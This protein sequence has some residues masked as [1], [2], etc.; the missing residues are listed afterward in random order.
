M[1]A[2]GDQALEKMHRIVLVR[3]LVLLWLGIGL[4][5]RPHDF[6]QVGGLG[7]FVAAFLTPVSLILLVDSLDK[8]EES[9]KQATS[10]GFLSVQVTALVALIEDDRAMLDDMT[11]KYERTREKSPAFGPVQKRYRERVGA[12]NGLVAG[13]LQLPEIADKT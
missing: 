5:G 12:L 4:F 2:R 11:R 6:E 7:T 8:Q 9:R 3:M 13:K 1:S 10:D